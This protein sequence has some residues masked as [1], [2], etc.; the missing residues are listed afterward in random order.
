[1]PS[2]V[3]FT[4]YARDDNEDRRL[5]RAVDA[6]ADRVATRLGLT[7]AEREHVVFFDST[8]ILTGQDW[9][10]RLGADLST[11]RVLVC[12]CSPRYLSREA[13]AK[14]FEIFRRRVEA[15]GG[16]AAGAIAILPVLWEHGSPQLVLPKALSRFQYRDDRLPA[17]YKESG[18]GPM[19]RLGSLRRQYEQT[20]E[21]LGQVVTD[22]F[23]GPPLPDYGGAVDF[24]TLPNFFSEACRGPYSVTVT[25]IDAR[26][27]QW[28][29]AFGGSSVGATVDALLD[30]L[31][32]PWREVP[33]GPDL[34]R[35][36]VGAAAER[37]ASLLV[38]PYTAVTDPAYAALLARV[39]ADAPD[40]CAA[41][42]GFARP[43]V[44]AEADLPGQAQACLPGRLTEWFFLDDSKS[45]V[46][47]VV[48]AV[49]RMRLA[50]VEKFPPRA[51]H[52]D[53]LAHGARDAQG[54]AVGVR[55]VL[56]GPSGGGR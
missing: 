34:P 55:P 17:V 47:G 25:V 40:T 21:V 29:P 3:F 38:L 12:L 9:E 41:V 20:I 13:C 53:A 44:Q 39:R 26:G 10:A 45:M 22:A 1:M 2:K 5:K 27:T 24:A 18:L 33:P 19:A 48:R 4:S 32:L 43:N 52:D 7:A 11:A 51:A 37:Q 56:A 42:V 28:K 8:D 30:R 15:A 50:L 49:E 35:E 54:L 46:D 31:K 23:A 14:E 6:I 16:P 36:L